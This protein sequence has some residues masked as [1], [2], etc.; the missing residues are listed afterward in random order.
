MRGLKLS[1][2][3]DLHEFARSHPEWVRGL[4]LTDAWSKVK[5][6]PVAPRVGAWIETNY[7]Y[8]IARNLQSHPEWVRGLKLLL[9]SLS[10][11]FS[12]SHPEWVRGL[13]QS[14]SDIMKQELRS[15]PEWVRGLKRHGTD[16]NQHSARRTPSGCVD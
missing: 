3:G 1:R 14:Q 2:V 9:V 5:S 13:K 16:I 8:A 15:H 6:T 12:M 7:R 10:L 11:L 4:K